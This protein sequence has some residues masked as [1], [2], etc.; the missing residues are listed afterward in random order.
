M[1]HKQIIKFIICGAVATSIHSIVFIGA[2]KIGISSLL[3]NTFAFLIALIVSFIMQSKWVFE[4]KKF[5]K[6]YLL[7]FIITALLGFISNTIIVFAIM[8]VLHKS[9]YLTVITMAIMTPSIT[10]I[11]NKLWVF[12]QSKN[13]YNQK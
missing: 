10:F 6:A 12:T 8:N 4:T 9:E 1:L 2:L 3:S 11:L 5:E 13:E 7:K